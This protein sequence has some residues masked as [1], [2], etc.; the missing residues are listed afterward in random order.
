MTEIRTG[1]APAGLSRNVF[2]ERFVQ[3][4]M[5]PAFRAE[6]E[7]ISRMEQIAWEAYQEGRKSPVTRK[8][9]PGY[10]DPDYELSVEWLDAKRPIRPPPRAC[11]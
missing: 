10:A 5:D 3:S 7:A 6:D 11:C 8:A 9:G 1:Q 2:H 4:F